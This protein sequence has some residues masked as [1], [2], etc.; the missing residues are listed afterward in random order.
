ML[1]LSH[2]SAPQRLVRTA[3]TAAASLVVFGALLASSAAP[4]SAATYIQQSANYTCSNALVGVAPPRVWANR[5]RPE[6]AVWLITIERWSGSRWYR[7]SQSSY[8][9][10]FNSFG[11][12]LTSWGRRFVNSRLRVPVS[13]RGYYRAA[14]AVAAPGVGSAVYVGGDSAYCFMP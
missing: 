7:Y 6:Q 10:T 14:S 4:A 11:Q 5:G 9:S 8:M 2:F 1:T 12:S 13:H 3:L